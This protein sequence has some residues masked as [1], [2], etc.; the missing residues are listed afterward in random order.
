MG[1]STT[2]AACGSLFVNVRKLHVLNC[3]KLPGLQIPPGMHLVI[4]AH[5]PEYM[6]IPQSVWSPLCW[7]EINT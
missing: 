7:S 1:V 3:L 6:L 4:F 2:A 5:V